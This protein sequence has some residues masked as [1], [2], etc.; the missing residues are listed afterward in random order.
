MNVLIFIVFA[1]NGK[2]KHI[3]VINTLLLYYLFGL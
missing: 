3:N 2:D 1:S